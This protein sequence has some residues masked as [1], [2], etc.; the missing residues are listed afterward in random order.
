MSKIISIEGNIGSGK[1]TI[2][3]LL[4]KKYEDTENIIFLNEPVDEW[5][6]IKDKNNVTMSQKFYENQEKYSFAFQ[7]M[8]YISR[9]SLLKD[10]IEKNPNSI[11]ITERC[12]NTDRYVFAK[13]LYDNNKLEDVEYQIYLKW[14]DHF[15]QLQQIQKV[16]YLK[17]DPEICFYRVGKRSRDGESTIS[18]EYLNNCH[19]YHE[20]MINSISN[21][22][23]V[24][25]GNKDIELDNNIVNNWMNTIH[26]FIYN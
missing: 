13:M 16:I 2:L 3:S 15:S 23:L 12:L 21:K 11:I 4:K 20:N 19:D 24:I 10:A 26:N 25:D 22:I 7:M 8:A 17:T 14:F 5:E 6:S 9:L 18:S 1:S